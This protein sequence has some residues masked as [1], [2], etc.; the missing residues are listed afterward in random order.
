MNIN[1][2]L[3]KITVIDIM[4]FFIV[5]L[6]I[7]ITIISFNNNRSNNIENFDTITDIVKDEI[8]KIYKTDVDSIRQ[9][10]NLSKS[11]MTDKNLNIAANTNIE[12]DLVVSGKTNV[13]GEKGDTGE[14]GKDGV[15]DIYSC[16]ESTIFPP[17]T[18]AS[19]P[20]NQDAPKGWAICDGRLVCK[21]WW[22]YVNVWIVEPYDIPDEN[23]YIRPGCESRDNYQRI[24]FYAHPDFTNILSEDPNNNK[25]YYQYIIKL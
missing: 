8:N 13:K 10:G 5:I 9:I 25:A 23:N 6:L 2:I 12:G 14:R 16:P 3:S 7:A 17:G 15:C 4:F 19:I 11:I 18:I 24:P 21:D 1:N 20:F 22:G